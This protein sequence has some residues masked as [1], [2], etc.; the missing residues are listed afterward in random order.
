V[1]TTPSSNP[2]AEGFK[3]VT[4]QAIKS[5]TRSVRKLPQALQKS[6][7]LAVAYAGEKEIT[8][9]ANSWKDIID[10]VVA[11]GLSAADGREQ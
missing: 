5:E 6:D 1:E 3:H 8:T 10:R 11:E 4:N 7:R 2:C 9:F